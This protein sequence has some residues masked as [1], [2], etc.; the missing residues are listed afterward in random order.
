MCLPRG[1]KIAEEKLWLLWEA[2]LNEM[3]ENTLATIVEVYDRLAEIVADSASSV[4]H[5][6]HSALFGLFCSTEICTQALRDNTRN[7]CCSCCSCVLH[8]SIA[9]FY[10][11]AL[12]SVPAL[13]TSESWTAPINSLI[14]QLRAHVANAIAKLDEYSEVFDRS[15]LDAVQQTLRFVDERLAEAKRQVD[16]LLR[17]ATA[18]IDEASVDVSAE[19]SAAFGQ[20]VKSAL[21][22]AFALA[23]R[24]L[25]EYRDLE[26]S[27]KARV[28]EEF[29]V[30]TRRLGADLK[31]RVSFLRNVRVLSTLLEDIR[32]RRRVDLSSGIIEFEIHA[33]LQLEALRKFVD[34]ALRFSANTKEL[35]SLDRLKSLLQP[36]TST[37]EQLNFDSIQSLLRELVFDGDRFVSVIENLYRRYIANN[38]RQL[39]ERILAFY[40]NLKSPGSVFDRYFTWWSPVEFTRATALYYRGDVST[41]G[42]KH[43]SID[44]RSE[45]ACQS[46]YLLTHYASQS[47]D[48]PSFSVVLKTSVRNKRST[49]DAVVLLAANGKHRVEITKQEGIVID[50]RRVDLPYLAVANLT[51]STRKWFVVIAQRERSVA[52]VQL[53]T[54]GLELRV[55]LDATAVEVIL[56]H[57][58][59]GASTARLSGLFGQLAG[60]PAEQ[61]LERSALARFRLGVKAPAAE[62]ASFELG[63]E[64]EAAADDDETA[65]QEAVKSIDLAANDPAVLER[66]AKQPLVRIC[67]YYFKNKHSPFQACFAKV[68]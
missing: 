21:Y 41:F 38:L 8:S 60:E 57:S 33:P 47:R 29:A 20:R 9:G 56:L 68:H 32:V 27:V 59:R 48:Q 16:Q 40:A 44:E 2:Q 13:R 17:N 66:L 53:P 63:E 14:D 26:Q 15:Q 25:F 1:L 5:S 34:D 19:V 37:A 18:A 7:L 30:F 61:L 31:E 22:T 43:F 45:A 24:F 12:R 23:K 51:H 6:M 28:R 39:R 58:T 46:N 67:A 42:G 49:I 11:R 64:L 35:L 36:S 10:K 54:Y 55:D 4:A 50:D 65:I 52:V 3:I 62:C